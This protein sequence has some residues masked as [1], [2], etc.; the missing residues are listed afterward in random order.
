MSD[1]NKHIGIVTIFN[2]NNFGAELQAYATQKAMQNLGYDAE[3]ID[4]P[5]YKSPNF[6]REKESY[7]FFP[8]PTAVKLKEK[9]A[10]LR[11]GLK[12]KFSSRKFKRRIEKFE[13]FH[14]ENTRFSQQRY[15]GISA[16]YNTPPQYD[17]Y[18]VGSDQ[19]WNPYNYVSLYPYFLTFSPDNARRMSYAS[20]FGVSSVP[21]AAKPV[22]SECLSKLSAISVR[23]QAGVT[24]VKELCD[25]PATLVCDPTLLLRSADWEQVEKK[26]EDLPSSYV[27]VYDLHPIPYLWVAAEHIARLLNLPI[28]RINSENARKYAGGVNLEDIGPAEFLYLFRHATFVVTNSFHGTAFS[29]NFQ[30]DFYCILSRTQRNNSRQLSLL[31]TCK[32]SHRALYE[33]ATLPSAEELSISYVEATDCLEQFRRTSIDFIKNAIDGPQ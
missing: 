24:L 18:C 12:Y 11:R 31:D 13:Q 4:L 2:V 17:V 1:P 30:K 33:D 5:Y 14:R 26:I 9:V 29:I 28:V 3:I 19:V 15:E 25:K 21:A 7:P 27:L 23:E 8:L 20:S 22:F 32:L 16:L 6:K 10:A